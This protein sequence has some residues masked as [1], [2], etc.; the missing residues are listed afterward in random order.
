MLLAFSSNLEVAD[1]S[2]ILITYVLNIPSMPLRVSFS[3]P[4]ETADTSDNVFLSV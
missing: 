4:F 1:P 2:G 3:C